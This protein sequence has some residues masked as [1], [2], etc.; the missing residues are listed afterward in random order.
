MKTNIL[1]L[2]RNVIGVGC[3]VISFSCSQAEKSYSTAT[4]NIVMEDTGETPALNAFE[5]E[6]EI[7]IKNETENANNRLKIIK[8]ASCRIKVSSVEEVTT[9]SKKIA[10]KYNG[11]VS[12]E[13]FTNTNYSKENRFTI[14]IPQ[15]KF[16]E[17]LDSIC[18]LAE[19]VDHK[20][21]STVDVTEEYIDINSR[22]KTKLEVKQRYETIL[23]TKAKNVEDILLTEDKLR[24]L[25]EEI[26]AAKGRLKYLSNKVSFST[27][28]L[29][30]YET[31]LPKDEPKK[32]VK[33]FIDRA[34]DGL[35]FGWNLL[36]HLF[37]VLFYVWPLLLL[38]VLIL[39]YYKWI[40]K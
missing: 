29:D 38:G 30:M 13:R 4:E 17:V 10:A 14:R 35:S 39:I 8:N 31:V 3:L 16:D 11:Y 19:F 36:Q 7:K 32:Y 18:A 15:D 21:I 40:R 25:Q 2:I 5:T 1:K 9:L 6:D 20:N 37:L 28:Q 33:S 22:L 23:R 34:E 26:D 12:D 24:E 27:I